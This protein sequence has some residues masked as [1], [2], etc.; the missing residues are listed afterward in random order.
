M[1]YRFESMSEMTEMK[2]SNIGIGRPKVLAPAAGVLAGSVAV[3]SLVAGCINGATSPSSGRSVRHTYIRHVIMFGMNDPSLSSES[4]TA[5]MVALKQM[6]AIG[7]D[8]IRLDA[9]WYEVQRDGRRT[10]DWTYLDRVVGSARAVGIAVDLVIDGCPPWAALAGTRGN[11]WSQP[12]SARLFGKWA[13]DVATRYAPQ[14][15][16]VFEIWNEQNDTKFW[17]PKPSPA[18][19]TKMLRAAFVA[20]KQVEPSAFVIAGGLAPLGT[21]G[22]NYSTIDFLKAMYAEGA[23]GYFDAVGTHPYTFPV[24]PETYEYWSGWSQITETSPSLRS[25][26]IAHG[27]GRKP[28]WITEFGAPSNGPLGVGLK[29]QAVELKQGIL[30]AKAENSIGAMYLYSWSDF[31]GDPSIN[32]DWFGLLTSRGRPKPAYA[33]VVSAIR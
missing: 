15:V 11:P 2:R 25:L 27:D 10:F 22:G 29:G 20:I 9:S 4:A 3:L 16:K 28:I 23:K 26:M 18:A 5:Q 24:L 8:S 21:N 14:G 32:G 17:Q 30:A 19:Y 13:K 7:I 31:G 6:K 33:A 12:A 1:H